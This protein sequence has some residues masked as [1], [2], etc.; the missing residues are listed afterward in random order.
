MGGAEGPVP[1]LVSDKLHLFTGKPLFSSWLW[2][3][4]SFL[5]PE[6]CHKNE[7]HQGERAREERDGAGA[8]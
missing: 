7:H 4:L 3:A 8:T 1:Q 6:E 2:N 5:G